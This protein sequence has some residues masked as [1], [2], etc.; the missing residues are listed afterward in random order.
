[1]LNFTLNL[2]GD[3]TKFIQLNRFYQSKHSFRCSNAIFSSFLPLEKYFI[4]NWFVFVQISINDVQITFKSW[5]R[6]N[7]FS[8]KIHF[9]L[10]SVFLSWHEWQFILFCQI[11][12]HAQF[13]TV[14][15]PIS[16]T[17][18]CPEISSCVHLRV[19]HCWYC[20]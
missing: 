16:Y 18:Q 11:H 1:M 7:L 3:F 15:S 5:I 2:R 10:N 12:L 19:N 17:G 9:E 8:E 4:G 13:L 14:S 6:T 20:S